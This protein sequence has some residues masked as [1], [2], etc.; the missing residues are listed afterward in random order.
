[1]H[2]AVTSAVLAAVGGPAL[3]T[4]VSTYDIK[5]DAEMTVNWTL[6]WTADNTS[7]WEEGLKFSAPPA[8]AQMAWQRDSYF[9]D[10]P[11]GHLGEPSGTAKAGDTLFRASKRGLHWLTLTDS[12]GAG[13]ALLPAEAPLVGRADTTATGTT[14]FASREVAGPHG[15]SGSWVENH[16]I[17]AVKGKSLSGSFT[18]RAIYAPG[19]IAAALK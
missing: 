2:V 11:A 19:L 3:G 18:L 10:Y 16:A 12:S 13:L 7:L 8:L 1:M 17:H 4:L 9:T 14:L 5:P 15:L 6:N